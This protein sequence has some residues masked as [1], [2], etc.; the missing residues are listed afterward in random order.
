MEDTA[1]QVFQYIY[2][3]ILCRYRVPQE[4]GSKIGGIC[5]YPYSAK[6]VR[7]CSFTK[8]HGNNFCRCYK[9]HA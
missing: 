1:K 9:C 5:T 3:H 8:F 4:N 2:V 6:F 7:I